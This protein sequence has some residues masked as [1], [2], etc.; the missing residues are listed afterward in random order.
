MHKFFTLFLVL[1]I[2][3]VTSSTASSYRTNSARCAVSLKSRNRL[4]STALSFAGSNSDSN[5][6]KDGT[7]TAVVTSDTRDDALRT[8]L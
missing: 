5:E 2:F 6:F 1:D 3:F 7:G 8:L 4:K